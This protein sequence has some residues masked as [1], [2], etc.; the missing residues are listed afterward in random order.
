[1]AQTQETV[2]S[3]R[4]AARPGC[5]HFG[6]IPFGYFIW[7]PSFI[8]TKNALNFRLRP[9]FIFGP[10]FWTENL[11][12]FRRRLFFGGLLVLL[13]I[14]FIKGVTSYW[15]TPR[16]LAPGATILSNASVKGWGYELLTHF[17]TIGW[18]FWSKLNLFWKKFKKIRQSCL[19]SSS[20]N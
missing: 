9:F 16:N 15:V 7:S 20:S 11:L 19:P 13:D 18:F 12:N 1:M 10:Y 14:T 6:V 5:H 8:W 2:M 3:P 17:W 4:G